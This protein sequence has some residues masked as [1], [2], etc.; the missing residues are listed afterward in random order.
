MELK[1]TPVLIVSDVRRTQ[2]QV[3]AQSVH[4]QIE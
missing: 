4:R 1:L 2:I 3:R